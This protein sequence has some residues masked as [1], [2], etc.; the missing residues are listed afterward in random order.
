MS[1]VRKIAFETSG[2]EYIF[3][4]QL[5]DNKDYIAIKSCLSLLLKSIEDNSYVF[6]DLSAIREQII[7]YVDW[8]ILAERFSLLKS[9]SNGELSFDK[10][11]FHIKEYA[12]SSLDE[13]EKALNNKAFL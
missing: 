12:F 4:S 1:M 5:N 9:I 11:G 2:K 7:V 13:V 3:L 6:L 10:E 8:L